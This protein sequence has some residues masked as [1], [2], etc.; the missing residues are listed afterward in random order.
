MGDYYRILGVE[1]TATA[2]EIKKAYRKLA[3]K[4]HPDKNPGNK[5]AEEKFKEISHAY[6]ILSNGQKRAQYDQFGEAAFQQGGGYGGFGFHDPSDI[7][8]E[9]F[10][11]SFG[12]IFD[13]M[14]GFGGS[15][16]RGPRKGRSLQATVTLDFFEAAK[17]VTKNIRVRRHE[18]CSSCNGSR[19][20]PGT[21]SKTCQ[22]CGGTGHVSQSGG[23]FS[24]SRTCEA[25]GGEGRIIEKPCRDCGGL[26]RKDVI[27]NIEVKVPAGVDDGMRLRLSGEGDPGIS[28]GPSGDLFVS[29]RVR[30]D[31]F[32]SRKNDDLLCV[33]PVSYTQLVFGDD[34]KVP[35]LDGE[36]DLSIPEGTQSG[37]VFRIRGKGIK[38]L[39]GRG[40][41]DQLVKVMVEIPKN[42]NARQKKILRDFEQSMGGKKATGGKN[43]LAKVKEFLS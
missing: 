34:V 15:R 9:V 26:G 23:F 17:G 38:R 18:V 24:I 3:V 31:R 12:D 32:F 2:E 43:I 36:V 1:S 13:G 27:K 22:R 35:G 11:G 41:G 42:L 25:C 5:E 29:I 30:E 7:F 28:G 37:R 10:G 16:R 8:R 40:R 21:E 14:F 4:Y 39:D 19:A 20:E 6:E 33:L